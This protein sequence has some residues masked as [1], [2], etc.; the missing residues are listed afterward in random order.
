[1]APPSRR[2]LRSIAA[3][4]ESRHQAGRKEDV[5]RRNTRVFLTLGLM[6]AVFALALTAAPAASMNQVTGQGYD[7]CSNL[8]AVC[9]YTFDPIE[10]CCIADPRFDCYDVC[11]E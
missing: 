11:F 2:V 10:G 1:V 6:I 7:P 3:D 8:P 4:I 5:M 9:R